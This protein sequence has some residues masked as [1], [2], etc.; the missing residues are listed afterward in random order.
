[1]P[2]PPP[3][4]S[5]RSVAPEPRSDG[6]V[7]RSGRPGMLEINAVHGWSEHAVL[8]A[9]GLEGSYKRP[10]EVMAEL[11]KAAAAATNAAI[12]GACAQTENVASMLALLLVLP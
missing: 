8:Y 7:T 3:C 4:R 11:V 6:R 12:E 10:E 1:M 2:S 5:P 9:A